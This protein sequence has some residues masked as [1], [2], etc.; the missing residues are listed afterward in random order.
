MFGVL[1]NIF[2]T[3]VIMAAVLV[4]LFTELLKKVVAKIEI[5][6]EMNGKQIKIFDY[7]KIWL[8]VFCAVVISVALVL[9]G[10]LEWKELFVYTPA[11]LGMAIFLYEAILKT[12][13][14]LQ[15]G[16]N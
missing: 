12:L 7:T 3:A 4:V 5:R 15:N 13:R 1:Q 9:A 8:A 11:I 16:E 2:P 6:L 10:F 14:K